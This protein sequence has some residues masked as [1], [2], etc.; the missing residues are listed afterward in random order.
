MGSCARFIAVRTGMNYAFW[1]TLVSGPHARCAGWAGWEALIAETTTRTIGLLV[2][3]EYGLLLYAPV[4]VARCGG[5]LALVKTR[6]DV[7]LSV[8][9]DGGSL[10][11]AHRL[12]VDE[13]ARLDR[14]LEP[15]GEVPDANHAAARPVRVRGAARCATVGHRLQ[16]WR[17]RSRSAPTC[18]ST[19]RCSGTTATAAPPFC[20]QIR[21][22]LRVVPIFQPTLARRLT[23]FHRTLSSNDSLIFASGPGFTGIGL[24]SFPIRPDRR[25]GGRRP[26]STVVVGGL[27]VDNMM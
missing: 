3:Q 15:G 27:V 12:P 24:P 19:P 6:R 14:R 26:A 22:R 16:S 5:A 7:A 11:R 10:R 21:R 4:Y 18:G 17:C 23:Y 13:R 1:G 25:A 2:D 8:F 9:A 20:E